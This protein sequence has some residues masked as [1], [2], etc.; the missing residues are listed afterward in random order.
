VPER[1]LTRV[2]A[3]HL[4]AVLGHL[5]GQ[6]P[7]GEAAVHLAVRMLT[8]RAARNGTGNLIGHDL[9]GWIGDEATSVLGGGVREDDLRRFP[10][11]G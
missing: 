8:L 10:L 2:E 11:G 1:L 6:A 5:P 3:G 4:R 9:T 7:R